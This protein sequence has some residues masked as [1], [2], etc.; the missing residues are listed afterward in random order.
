MRIASWNWGGR[1]YVGTVSADGRELT[2]LRVADASHG[3]M[4]LIELLLRGEP[5]PPADGARLP[6]NAVTLRA[7]LPRPH[8]NL[9][10]VGRNYRAHAQ[11]LAASGNAHLP[12]EIISAAL[13][14][15]WPSPCLAQPAPRL[16]PCSDKFWR[17]F[18]T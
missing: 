3:A 11:E 15:L 12:L 10:C 18:P 4:P 9:F 2:P 1:S 7:P 16:R 8:R 17:S 5:L 6:I 14:F 13:L